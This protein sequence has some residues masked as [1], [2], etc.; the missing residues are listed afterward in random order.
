MQN[1]LARVTAQAPWSVTQSVPPIYHRRDLHWLP[2]RQRVIYKLSTK[3]L[4][5]CLLRFE[6]ISSET[7][8]R[9]T[10]KFCTQ[11][12]ADHVQDTCWVYVYRGRRYENNDI[13]SKNACRYA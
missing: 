4:R 11:T 9:T 12:R 6:P 1:V 10:A 5:V 8:R 3:Y 7:P 13:F 2:I